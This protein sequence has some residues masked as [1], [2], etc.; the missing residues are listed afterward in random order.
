MG[1]EGLL[2]YGDVY[3]SETDPLALSSLAGTVFLIAALSLGRPNRA[4]MRVIAMGCIPVALA[5]IL[6]SGSRGQLIGSAVGAV[7]SLPIALRLKISKSI[8]DRLWS[9]ASF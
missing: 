4:L 6:K 2:L 5:V 3:E 9:P 1:L 8:A 7:V